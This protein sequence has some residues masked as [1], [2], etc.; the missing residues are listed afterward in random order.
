M[1]SLLA[2]VLLGGM[3]AAAAQ[4]APSLGAAASFA[5]LSGTSVVSDGARVG[6]NVGVS[7]GSTISGPIAFTV[8]TTFRNDRAA[9]AAQRDYAEAYG[10][11]AALACKPL[12]DLRPPPGVYCIEIGRA[13]GRG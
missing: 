6:G 10:T 3:S 12:P 13:S 1:R 5:V 9:S 8:G 11:L 2:I 4:R 7:P